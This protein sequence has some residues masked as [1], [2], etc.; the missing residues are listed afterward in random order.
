MWNES[1]LSL[2][3]MRNKYA[4]LWN[5]WNE[6]VLLLRYLRKESERHCQICGT[7][8]SCHC[9]IRYWMKMLSNML[10]ETVLQH[11]IFGMN[12]C[13]I[14]NMWNESDRSLQYMWNEYVHHCQICG[15]NL[16]CC[17]GICGMNMCTIVKYVEWICPVITVNAE[18]ICGPLSN[19]CNE[20]VLSLRYLRK[21]SVHHCQICWTNLYAEWICTPL[22]NM[23][24]E[25]VLSL[26]YTRIE[27]VRLCCSRRVR[28]QIF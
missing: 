2:Q 10:N 19:M 27:S 25:S 9:S 18:W 13:A 16:S 24:N 22:S 7:N 5:M 15:M 17:Y 4:P 12:M 23:W 14:I 8:L 20:S 3:Y 21:V 28:Y 26:R 1:V 11:G 6:S